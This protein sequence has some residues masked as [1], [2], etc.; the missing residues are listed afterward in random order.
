[1]FIRSQLPEPDGAPGA[2]GEGADPIGTLFGLGGSAAPL[3]APIPLQIGGAAGAV[4]SCPSPSGRYRY[5][6]KAGVPRR[7][8]SQDVPENNDVS[9]EDVAHHFAASTDE[10]WRAVNAHKGMQVKKVTLE[11]FTQATQL[12]IGFAPPS[13]DQAQRLAQSILIRSGWFS[14]KTLR[15]A[16][17]RRLRLLLSERGVEDAQNDEHLGGFL[18]M[19]LAARPAVLWEAQKRALAAAMTTSQADDLPA[20]VQS[21]M[22]LTTSRRNVYGVYPAEDFNTWERAFGEYL[23]HDET[24]AVLWW[25]RNPPRK[26]WSINVLLDSG[27]G[28]YPDFIIGVDQRKTADHGLL[29]DTKFAWETTPEFPKLLAEHE[30]YGKALILSKNT[31]DMKWW[32][33]GIDP[34]GRPKLERPFRISEASRY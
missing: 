30:T 1:V 16:L 21:D 13:R 12:E 4:L 17:L 10:L 2:G 3:S 5:P 26:A 27:G 18:N 29:A 6:L 31:Q 20:E 28:F 22:P 14:P 8:M 7:F 23:D 24:G 11:I 9:E 34:T 19:M 25:H 33:A 32:V 15:A